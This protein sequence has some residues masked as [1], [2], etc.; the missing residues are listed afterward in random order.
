MLH[1]HSFGEREFD[2]IIVFENGNFGRN[3]NTFFNKSV[4][5]F[6]LSQFEIIKYEFLFVVLRMAW[7]K[8]IAFDVILSVNANLLDFMAMKT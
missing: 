5:A 4:G 8:E 7:I 6:Y 2:G 1:F 3:Q